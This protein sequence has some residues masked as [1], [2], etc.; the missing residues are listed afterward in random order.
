MTVAIKKKRD[1]DGLSKLQERAVTALVTCG[2]IK[3][4]AEAAGV[5]EASIYRWLKLE[6]FQRA[7]KDLRREAVK[8][9]I[10]KLQRATAEAV[11]VLSEVM[12]GKENIPSARVSAAK[13]IIEQ[14]FKA[15]ELEDLAERIEALE[16]ALAEK[17]DNK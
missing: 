15:T 5:N 10:S 11:E 2:T 14:A 1:S 4:A 8:L 16:Q 7:Y 13:T 12:K 17:G 9:A 3:E 6:T